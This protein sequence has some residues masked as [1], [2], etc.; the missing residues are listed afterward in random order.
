MH[1]E[2]NKQNVNFHFPSPMI[3]NKFQLQFSWIYLVG[4]SWTSTK[5]HE[6]YKAIVFKN[7]DF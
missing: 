3:S 4:L 5:N 2:Q 6:A 7:I 1:L